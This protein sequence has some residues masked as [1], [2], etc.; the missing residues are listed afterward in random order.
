[1]ASSGFAADCANAFVAHSNMT[2]A[3]AS[4]MSRRSMIP[5]MF[6]Y[7]AAAFDA[8]CGMASSPRLCIEQ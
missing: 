3:I 4:A 6:Y 5:R 2:G 1:M 7:A 8:V